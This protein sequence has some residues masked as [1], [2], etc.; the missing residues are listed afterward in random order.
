MVEVL[1]PASVPGAAVEHMEITAHD[2]DYLRLRSLVR[3]SRSEWTPA[4]SYMRLMI[5]GQLWMSDTHHEQRSNL[6]AVHRAH[7]RVLVGGLGL[8][9]V[10]VAMLNKPQVE[11]VTVIERDKRVIQLVATQLADERLEVVEGDVFTWRPPSATLYDTIYF[12]IWLDR[13]VDNLT[14]ITRLKRGYARRLNRSSAGGCWMGAWEEK[15]LRYLKRSGRW[16]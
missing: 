9:M 14:E 1:R 5:D 12:D 13:C 3:C 10:V 6:E 15:T 7:G 16:R 8:G 11:R 2:E 4:G